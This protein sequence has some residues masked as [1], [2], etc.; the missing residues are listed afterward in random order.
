MTQYFI[1]SVAVI[2]NNSYGLVVLDV[3]R[4]TELEP[5][6]YGDYEERKAEKTFENG[7]VKVGKQ[8]KFVYGV[9]TNAKTRPAMFDI[10]AQ[11]VNEEPESLCSE[12]I[13]IELKSLVTNKRGKPEALPGTHDDCIMSYLITRYALTNGKSFQNRFGISA[14]MTSANAKSEQT[15]VNMNGFM[16]IMDI[17]N[18]GGATI[19][20]SVYNEIARQQSMLHQE[21]LKENGD[22]NRLKNGRLIQ[23]DRNQ[24]YRTN[25]SRD[26]ENMIWGLNDPN[27]Y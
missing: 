10:L 2:E 17:G 4:K 7:T 12:D 24:I 15:G 13:F 18:N 8:K 23:H 14:M 1:H 19:D 26:L 11:I 9:S 5:R 25:A 6:L 3:L 21:D 27:N 20:P 16:T 22:P